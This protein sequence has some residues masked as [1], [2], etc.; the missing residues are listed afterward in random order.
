[1]VIAIV[2]NEIR[3]DNEFGILL[4]RNLQSGRV[5][6]LHFVHPTETSR[7]SGWLRFT[8]SHTVLHKRAY[9]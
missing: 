3:F 7:K 8:V 2:F 5:A 6:R 9:V 4:L 1:M